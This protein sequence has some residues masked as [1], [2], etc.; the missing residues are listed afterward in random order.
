[1]VLH[2]S[3][4]LAVL[5]RF[6]WA[7]ANRPL[8]TTA[9]PIS[10]PFN[11]MEMQFMSIGKSTRLQ[12][13][14]TQIWTCFRMIML[15]LST[16]ILFPCTMALLISERLAGW[17]R[18]SWASAY[19][20]PYTKAL[21][22]SENLAACKRDSW[23]SK[24]DPSERCLSSYLIVCQPETQFLIIIKL[25][26]LHYDTAHI[27]AFGSLKTRFLR[28][29][30]STPLTTALPIS[31][32][33]APRKRDSWASANKPPTRSFYTFP[34]IWQYENEILEHQKMTSLHHGS[35]QFLGTSKST[36][37]Y[38]RADHMVC[39][40]SLKTQFLY[41]SNWLLWMMALLKS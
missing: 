23:A 34:R 10:D 24:N 25:I 13:S 31:E 26:P 30:K 28:I 27:W 35:A 36:R 3:E 1:M 12:D 33:L 39:F 40:Y 6:S 20:T 29:S 19:R 2:M 15:F 38:K 32:S 17:K 11:S 21:N 5:K 41:I 4:R 16:S 9:L 18:D 37:L 22:I 7:Y 8:Y 14:N